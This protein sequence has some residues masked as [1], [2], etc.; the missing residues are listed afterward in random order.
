MKLEEIL[1]FAKA[2]YSPKE[3]KE[4]MEL[5]NVSRETSGEE[6]PKEESKTEDAP[7]EETEDTPKEETE[8]LPNYKEL[9]EESQK[10][11]KEAQE[12]NKKQNMKGEDSKKSDVDIVSDFVRSF[13]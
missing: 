11:L 5:E 7:K 4:L 8:E 1:V 3:V 6:V 12:F 10:K 13:M 9:Y 2:G